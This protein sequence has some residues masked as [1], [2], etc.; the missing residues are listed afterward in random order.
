MEFWNGFLTGGVSVVMIGFGAACL[1][2]AWVSSVDQ[3]ARKLRLEQDLV[4]FHEWGFV[5]RYAS[6][7]RESE[8]DAG[9]NGQLE[10]VV[11][12]EGVRL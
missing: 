11:P 7:A 12:T 2:S 8:R 4:A 3:A 1:R 5:P 9:D 6:T 10:L